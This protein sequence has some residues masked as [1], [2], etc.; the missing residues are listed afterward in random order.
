MFNIIITKFGTNYKMKVEQ[1]TTQ[2]LNYV[3]N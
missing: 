2:P 1:M 3:T